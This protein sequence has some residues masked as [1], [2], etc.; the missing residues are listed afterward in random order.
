M[1]LIHANLEKALRDLEHMMMMRDIVDILEC[2]KVVE[3][4]TWSIITN[5]DDGGFEW[6]TRN[7]D[8]KEWLSN[9]AD[10]IQ[11]YVFASCIVF[12]KTDDYRDRLD[13][14]FYVNVTRGKSLKGLTIPY[15]E[16]ECTMAINY[17]KKYIANEVSDDLHTYIKTIAEMQSATV[18][19]LF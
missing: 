10:R 4:E 3:Q 14:S 8:R 16:G 7:I 11:T 6:R 13:H 12:I 17:S 18:E 9:V 2:G 19:Y 1:I 15:T 5:D